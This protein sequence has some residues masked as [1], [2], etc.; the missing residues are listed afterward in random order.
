MAQTNSD[1]SVELLLIEDNLGDVEITRRILAGSK[2]DLN[3][4]VAE[5]GEVAMTY[6][7]QEGTFAQK[8]RP[9]LILLDLNM[10]KKDGYQVM[11][12]LRADPALQE[13]PVMVLTSTSAENEGL[14]EQGI[15]P[16]SFCKKPLNLFQFDHFVSQLGSEVIGALA[17]TSEPQPPLPAPEPDKPAEETKR[18][19]PFG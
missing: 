5:D 4:N 12:E 16:N 17:T 13:L 19:W 1:K 11:E 10:P 9:D 3:I 15:R 14:Y 18:L 7:R 2:F 6:L 8:P